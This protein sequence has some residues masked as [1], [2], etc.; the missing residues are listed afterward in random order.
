MGLCVSA[1]VRRSEGKLEKLVLSF[2]HVIPGIK[3]RS[4]SLEHV[5]L[6]TKKSHGPHNLHYRG[7]VIVTKVCLYYN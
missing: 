7:K 2:Q 3:L 5:V 1:Q 6:P 4:L